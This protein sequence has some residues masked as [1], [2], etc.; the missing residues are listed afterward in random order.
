MIYYYLPFV[1]VFSKKDAETFETF[2]TVKTRGI[3]LQIVIIVVEFVFLC[4]LKSFAKHVLV[5]CEDVTQ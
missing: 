4:F 5:E 2:E 1:C 3:A